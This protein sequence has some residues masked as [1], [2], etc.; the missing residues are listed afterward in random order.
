MILIIKGSSSRQLLNGL[1]NISWFTIFW[2]EKEV[3]W[4]ANSFFICTKKGHSR[5]LSLWGTPRTEVEV[6]GYPNPVFKS[7]WPDEGCCPHKKYGRSSYLNQS[8][9]DT[10]TV[11]ISRN[12]FCS[13]T[14]KKSNQQKKS[15][16]NIFEAFSW[17]TF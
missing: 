16:L 14:R 2:W 11:S 7:S 1:G 6:I 9:F 17:K 5:N 8:W 12:Q 4:N 10:R 3:F 15:K 13:M